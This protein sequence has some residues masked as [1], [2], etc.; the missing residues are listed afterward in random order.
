MKLGAYHI[1]QLISIALSVV[2]E[3]I[4]NNKGSPFTLEITGFGIQ[5][6]DQPNPL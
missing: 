6:R 5:D 2:W 3:P 1:C 4:V